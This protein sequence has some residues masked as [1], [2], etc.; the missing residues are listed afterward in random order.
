M[1]DVANRVTAFPEILGPDGLLWA[2][3]PSWREEGIDS[4]RHT[5]TRCE[6]YSYAHRFERDVAEIMAGLDS[7]DDSD[8]FEEAYRR[9]G[10]LLGFHADNSDGTA[11]P[12]PWW[13][14]GNSLCLVSEAKNDSNPEHAVPVRH[15]RQAASHP[16][17]IRDNVKL[18][19]CAEIH[20]VMITPARS[21][22]PDVPT[23]AGDV[24]WWQI[25]EFREWARDAIGVLRGVRAIFTGPGNIAWRD[26]VRRKM[27]EYRLDPSSI[28]EKATEVL[29]RDVPIE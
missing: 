16:Q 13:I 10:E 20:T 22:H 23:Y 3:L 8:A 27:I 11:T 9:F 25:D 1:K 26:E 19:E 2:K 21:A 4:R 18:D 14:S 15:T 7:D 5:C 29:L 12:D 28:I 17:W 24:G 6:G